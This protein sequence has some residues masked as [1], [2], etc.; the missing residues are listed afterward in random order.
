MIVPMKK[1]TVLVL[2]AR[3]RQALSNL[4]RLGLLHPEIEQRSDEHTDA[5][6]DDRELI[7]RALADL[8]TEESVADGS[9]DEDAGTST[10]APA[11]ID[12]ALETATKIRDC[13]EH[14]R[15]AQ[16]SLGKI[17]TEI[18]RAAPWGEFDP[19]DVREL[20]E[21]GVVVRLYSTSQKEFRKR[22]PKG[23]VI[24]NR[25][26][27]LVRFAEL[28]YLPVRSESGAN[29]TSANESSSFT[30]FR[31]PD[32]PLSVLQQRRDEVA[33]EVAGTEEELRLLS[34]HRHELTGTLA[35]IDQRLRDEY[36]RLG[37][38]TDE[39]VAFITGY[40]PADAVE[41]LREAA[42]RHGWGTLIRDPDP[43][44]NVPTKVRNR[45][46]VNLIRPVFSFLGVVPGYTERD[47]SFFFLLFFIV[48][49][50]MIIGDAGYGALLLVA[51]LFLLFR[52][53]KEKRLLPALLVVLGCS[54]IGWG[55]ITGNWFGYP[56]IG[57]LYPFSLAVVP[58]LDS[59]DV[60]STE[61]V[62][63]ISFLLAV[64]HLSL[65]RVWNFITQIRQTPRIKAFAQLGWLS[66]VIGMYLLVMSLFIGTVFPPYGLYLIAGGLGAVVI[67]GSQSADRGFLGG[68]G[69]GFADLF[70]SFISSIGAFSDVVSYIRL[71]AVGLATVQIAQAF[72][73]MAAGVSG[74][75]V[76]TAGAALILA[77]GHTL[78]VVMAGL[79]VIVHGV[80]L[81]LLEF[82]G[83]LGMEWTGVRYQ[84][85]ADENRTT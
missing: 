70:I 53:N 39:P 20:E 47:I 26:S 54:T 48:F 40:L 79:A 75:V 63:R 22:A 28:A 78:N 73:A 37:M 38:D 21:R 62:Q 69:R 52:A 9:P 61:M 5:L 25:T 49:V 56:P 2:D 11:G 35:L 60:R 24:L 68:L 82:S 17:E 4:K 23:A 77:F 72:N 65:A 55:A 67:F 83:H 10:L 45:G 13:A 32:E 15:S 58:S 84:P 1:A 6:S 7:Q 34:R 33:S 80:R 76:G 19:Q 64:V 30:E 8:P 42:T 3:R 36:V 29:G 66:L 12:G 14:A 51:S 57:D 59:F 85:Y 46:P 27:A 71:F 81:N 50:G 16:E 74:G 43:Q 18:A 44:D 41:T 31:I